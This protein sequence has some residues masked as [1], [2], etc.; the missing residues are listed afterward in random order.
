MSLGGWVLF[1][2]CLR[3]SVQGHGLR[4]R[5]KVAQTRQ[6]RSCTFSGRGRPPAHAGCGRT[7][8]RAPHPHHPS[9]SEVP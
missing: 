5:P 2:L 7:W 3:S 4:G 8:D 6:A 9:R 1:C